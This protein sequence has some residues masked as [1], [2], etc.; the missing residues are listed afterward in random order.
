MS[1]EG[2]AALVTGGSR[3]IGRAVCLELARQGAAVAVNYA[4]SIQAAEETVRQCRQLGVEAELFQADVA[5]PAACD[6]LVAAVKE[7]FGRLDILVNN[8]GISRDGLLM[9]A[10][11]EDFSKTLDTN[12][13]GAYFCTKAAAKVMLRQK[14]GRIVSLSSVVGLRGNPGQTAYAA[15]KAGILGLTKAAAK[16]LAGRDIT[17]NAVAPGYIATDMTA[18]LPEKAREAMLTTIPKGR[19]GTPEEVARAVAF[20]AQRESAYV[21]GQVLCVDGGMAV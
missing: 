13:K 21:T 18:A 4:G 7:R 15:S 12:L 9:T 20:F 1:L 17:V 5:S 2:M 10:K 11:E 6:A 14:Y 19:P 8:A 3:G 16:E